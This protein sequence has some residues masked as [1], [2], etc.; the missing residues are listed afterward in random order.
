[1]LARIIMDRELKLARVAAARLLFLVSAGTV[2]VHVPLPYFTHA[3]RE[4]LAS[5]TRCCSL[6]R[7][8]F[9]IQGRHFP[10]SL[11]L[12]GGNA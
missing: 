4:P 11:A 6:A 10:N 9:F 1:M 7:A 8:Y 12:S 3:V 2:F 5:L